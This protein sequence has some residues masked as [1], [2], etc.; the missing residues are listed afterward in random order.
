MQS[1]VS[2]LQLVTTAGSDARVTAAAWHLAEYVTLPCRGYIQL[3]VPHTL[4]VEESWLDSKIKCAANMR[5]DGTECSAAVLCYLV[6]AELVVT[7]H[8]R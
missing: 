2:C 8:H 4:Q 3:K 7:S 5:L 6:C 1:I